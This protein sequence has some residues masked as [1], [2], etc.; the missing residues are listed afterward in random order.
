MSIKI[1][2]AGYGNLGR[3][4]ECAVL[5]N[6]DMELYGVFT[7]RD[8]KTVKTLTNLDVYNIDDICN[9]K[10]NID[11]VIICGGSATD[12]PK[13]TPSL[14]EYFNVIDS[15][16]THAKIP[17]HFEKVDC[18]AKKHGNIAMISK[19]IRGGNLWNTAWNTTP[20]VKCRCLQTNTGAHRPREVFRIFP[21]A[22]AW[23]PCPLRSSGPSAY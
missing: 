14:V 3:G 9:H 20:W 21:L 1:A 17:E 10:D 11:V 5:Q 2:I 23:R 15:F 7:R 19:N 13:Q 12:L 6:S 16:D 22:W 8:P 4:V 18:A